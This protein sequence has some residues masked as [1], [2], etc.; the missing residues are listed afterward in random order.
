MVGFILVKSHT[1]LN[2]FSVYKDLISA[3]RINLKQ[4]IQHFPMLSESK[5]KKNYNI[6]VHEAY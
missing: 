5:G 2:F 1:L 4:R 3:K 6:E